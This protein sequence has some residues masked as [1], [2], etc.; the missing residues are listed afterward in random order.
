MTQQELKGMTEEDLKAYVEH[1]C[2]QE[3]KATTSP[4]DFEYFINHKIDSAWWIDA[5][6]EELQD[7]ASAN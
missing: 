4:E 1:I 5:T 7:Y 6:I 2:V 3:I